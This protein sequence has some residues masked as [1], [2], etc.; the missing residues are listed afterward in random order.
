MPSVINMSS[1]RQSLSILS[2]ASQG[3]PV[4]KCSSLV[5]RNE[6]ESR[7]VEDQLADTEYQY[8]MPASTDSSGSCSVAESLVYPY[9]TT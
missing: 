8:S 3:E 2:A 5:S 9:P 6:E 1:L 7:Q 4:N